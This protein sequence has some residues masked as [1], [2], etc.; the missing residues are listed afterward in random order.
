[1]VVYKDGSLEEIITPYC[2]AVQKIVASVF[3]GSHPKLLALSSAMDT[4]DIL[5][6]ETPAVVVDEEMTVKEAE[7]SANAAEEPGKETSLKKMEHGHL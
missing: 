6:V 3:P 4:S 1:M 7:R 5:D 2:I